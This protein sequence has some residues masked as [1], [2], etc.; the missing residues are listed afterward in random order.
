MQLQEDLKTYFRE[1]HDPDHELDQAAYN[2]FWLDMTR[3]QGIYQMRGDA[4]KLAEELERP[5]IYDRVALMVVS[6]YH[7]AHWRLDVT[8][9]NY[10]TAGDC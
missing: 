9:C 2:R 4:R 10:L 8:V 6:V 1:H 3:N 7:L 5:A